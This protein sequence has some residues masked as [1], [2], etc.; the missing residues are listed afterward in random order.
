MKSLLILMFFVHYTLAT[1]LCNCNCPTSNIE[2]V[3]GVANITGCSESCTANIS[4]NGNGIW[5]GTY[6]IWNGVWSP[7][8][9]QQS[10]CERVQGCCFSGDIEIVDA[11]IGAPL[12][13]SGPMQ[14]GGSCF[15]PV[16]SFVMSWF[17]R[18]S[19]NPI[20]FTANYQPQPSF[21]KA[22][23]LSYDKNTGITLKR[24]E[25]SDQLNQKYFCK[26]GECLQNV[27]AQNVFTSDAVDRYKR[28][29]LKFTIVVSFLLILLLST[30]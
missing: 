14:G 26:L 24:V 4:C 28:Q 18:G 19:S 1:V 22:I 5:I 25:D 2:F 20:T 30:C 13:G 8:P 6:M 29:A 16:T 21:Q 3:V 10:E 7:I 9:N 23:E 11:D 15:T 17:Y 12:V 27:G